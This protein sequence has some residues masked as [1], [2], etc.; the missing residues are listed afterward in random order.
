MDVRKAY[1]NLIASE[2]NILTTQVAVKQAEEEYK[3]A[4]VKYDEGVGTNLEVMDAQEKLTESQTNF[5]TALYNYNVSKAQ[6][7][8]AMGVPIY[9]DVVLYDESVQN[10]KSAEMALKN[11]ILD[12]DTPH[13]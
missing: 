2:K 4:Q 8:K 11:S 10:G 1:N 13:S 3:I 9:I 6:L 7:D 12:V 5:F